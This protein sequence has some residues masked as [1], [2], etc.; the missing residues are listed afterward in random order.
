MLKRRR[1]DVFVP[2]LENGVIFACLSEYDLNREIAE[3][4]SRKSGGVSSA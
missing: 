2:L 1:G 4:Y 3:G